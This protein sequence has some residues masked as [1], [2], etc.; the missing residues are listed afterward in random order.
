MQT[1]SASSPSTSQNPASLITIPIF[2]SEKPRLRGGGR[3]LLEVAPEEAQ[4]S[5]SLATSR[6]T[7]DQLFD[8]Q[9][10]KSSQEEPGEASLERGHWS[11][12]F[13]GV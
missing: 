12:G 4:S 1:L 7:S 2:G 6:N 10:I 5:L 13:V 8:T 11:W 3:D 9:T